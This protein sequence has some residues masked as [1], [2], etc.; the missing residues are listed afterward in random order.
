MKVGARTTIYNANMRRQRN[1]RGL[2]QV[3][4]AK[5]CNVSLFVT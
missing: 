2:T 1:K 3:E 5:L 4:L